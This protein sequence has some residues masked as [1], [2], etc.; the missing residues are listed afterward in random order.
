[1]IYLLHFDEPYKH[2]RHYLGCT[3]N[4]ANRLAQHA[5]G[6][7]ARLVQ[8][9]TEAGIGF[10]LAR[11]WEGGR[12]GERQL[13]RHKHGPRHCPI[14]QGR[15]R[16]RPLRQYGERAE[17]RARCI[18]ATRRGSQCSRYRRHGR[19]RDETACFCGQHA[20]LIAAGRSVWVP[21]PPDGG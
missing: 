7:G 14:C 6:H 11:T 3:D 16:S 10:D 18:A 5:S 1:M 9:V 4:L 17:S 12:Q 20:N 13:K 19:Y 8:V 2:A 21:D 15:A